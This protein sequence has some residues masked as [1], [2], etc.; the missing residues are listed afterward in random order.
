MF[1]MKL[2]LKQVL[3]FVKFLSVFLNFSHLFYIWKVYVFVV[4]LIHPRIYFYVITDKILNIS[5]FLTFPNDR[6]DFDF[7]YF[8]T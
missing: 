7:V 4:I 5:C 1:T 2:S 3:A 6:T 8:Y